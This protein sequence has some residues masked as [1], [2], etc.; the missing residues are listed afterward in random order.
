MLMAVSQMFAIQTELVLKISVPMHTVVVGLVQQDHQ[1]YQ[2]VAL[3]WR[4]YD[5]KTKT[6]PKSIVLVIFSSRNDEKI[7][8]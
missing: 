2:G 8:I 1:H 3:P 6:I 5:E 7:Y 4:V